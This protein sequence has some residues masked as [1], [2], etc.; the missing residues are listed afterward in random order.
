MHPEVYILI[1]P[2]FGICSQGI[3]LMS[4][5]YLFGSQSMVLAMGCISILGS[6]VWAHHMYLVGLEADTRGYFTA[7]TI[8]ISLPTGT[9]V[10]NW[11]STYMGSLLGLSMS[12]SLFCLIFLFT[13]TLG[14]TTG[15]ILGNAAVD[16]ALHDTYYV[17][18]HFHLVLSLGAI[19]ALI[20]GLFTFQETLF[21]GAC[22]IA[23]PTCVNPKYHFFLFFCGINLTFLPLHFLGFHQMPR[24]I[25][26]F[27]DYFLSW[28]VISSLG[29]QLTFLALFIFDLQAKRENNRGASPVPPWLHRSLRPT[30]ELYRGAKPFTGSL[31]LVG[32]L[33][34]RLLYSLR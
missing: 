3:S 5:K 25:P 26:D 33:A 22:M 21:G 23:H 14:G 19:I 20:A 16:V 27:P 7:L 2:A 18:A 28:N 17:V 4:Q 13:F 12:S 30:S 8:M 24:R 15:V 10:F 32:P 6:C 11:A 34:Y 9:K 31:L 29:S 1:L